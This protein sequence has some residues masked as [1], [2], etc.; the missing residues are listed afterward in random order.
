MLVI[1]F[2]DLEINRCQIIFLFP[3]NFFFILSLILVGFSSLSYYTLPAAGILG[4]PWMLG[5]HSKNESLLVC[6]EP[7]IYYLQEGT[8]VGIEVAGKERRKRIRMNSSHMACFEEIVRNCLIG[9]LEES[10]RSFNTGHRVSLHT[11]ASSQVW[12]DWKVRTGKRLEELKASLHRALLFAIFYFLS[13][14]WSRAQWKEICSRLAFSKVRCLLFEP[15][16]CMLSQD[17][18][19]ICF[20]PISLFVGN[21]LLL[22]SFWIAYFAPGS[23]FV[24][25]ISIAFR[26]NS[27]QLS[28]KTGDLSKF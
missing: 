4:T 24:A 22:H 16:V 1:F 10:R 25:I 27:M 14:G 28:M 3:F 18:W 7:C 26:Q 9:Q 23:H 8:M 12:V 21:F 17:S 19:V 15:Q 6:K 2:S 5:R 20:T 13:N 11:A